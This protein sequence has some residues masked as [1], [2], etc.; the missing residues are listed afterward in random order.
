[1]I[2]APTPGGS[3]PA[4]DVYPN[5]PILPMLDVLRRG[6]STWI[7]KLL[8]LVLVVSF[9]VW[10]I[11]DVFRGF[12]SN[13][14]YHV[15]S[16]EIGVMELDQNY[17]RELQQVARRIGRPFNKDEA[18]KTGVAQ[19]ILGRI[20]TDATIGEA[21]RALRLDVS[22]A[23][24]REEIVRDP[25]FKGADGAFSRAHFAELLRSNG[26]NEDMY[27][28]RRRADVVRAQLLE[29]VSGGITAPRVFVE[30]VDR[31]RNETRVVRH[32]TLSVAALGTLPEPTD[33]ELGAFFEGR[34]AQFRTHETRNFVAV[35]LDAKTLARPDDVTADDAK[36]EY[37]RQ[38]A[39]FTT[40]EKRRVSQM[41][42]DD[43]AAAEAALAEIKAGKSFDE[44]AAARGLKTEEIDLGLMDK[45]SFLDKTIGEAAFAL[46][47]V[48]AVSPVVAGRVRPV[49]LKL[50]ERAAGSETP[51]AEARAQLAGE[52]AQKRAE[53]DILDRFKQVEDAIA[54]GAPLADV[55]ARFSLP[56]VTVAGLSQDG[57]AADGSSP[58][59]PKLEEVV[60]GVFESDVGVENTAI[61]LGGKGFLWYAL[62][63]V[64][65]ARDRTLDEARAAATAAWKA[66]ET[67]LRLAEKGKE[68]TAQLGQGK[69]FDEVT[70][71]F[72][73]TVTTSAAFKRE[74]QVAGLPANAVAA[75]FGGPEG[76]VASVPGPGDTQVIL[77]VADVT[78]A[79]FFAD[80]PEAK[81]IA[82]RAASSIR[83]SVLQVWLGQVQK[84]IGV[85]MNRTVVGRVT[86]QIQ[87]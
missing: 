1:M 58:A 25:T 28:M 85:T 3:P 36:A 42:F 59:L 33:K 7:S 23:V 24:I 66:Q 65:P 34:K 4:V 71:A 11:A 16:R 31:F 60:K 37:D 13:T 27:V 82:E 50:T 67:A 47:E 17:T 77:Q 44:I 79:V 20:V 35:V 75:A 68:I 78:P 73:L 9:G 12:G 38:K 2:R 51:F 49:I 53:A 84:D 87:N 32:A 54:G 61:D 8:L 86:G 18:L 45:A 14:A 81:A 19:Q 39:R 52:I 64:E 26:W 40:P 57:K 69:S 29:G 56:V 30:A 46:P 48:G 62:T 21:A 63:A 55:G 5:G 70:A 74:E 6:A 43:T 80:G 15:G 72:G 83:E 76:H 10:G 22:D 41:A